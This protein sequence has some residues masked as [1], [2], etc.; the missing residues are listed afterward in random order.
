MLLLDVFYALP[1]TAGIEKMD[2][3]RL[4]AILTTRNAIYYVCCYWCVNIW[5]CPAQARTT[6]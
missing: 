1:S 4:K 2:T 6:Q 3:S 5:K